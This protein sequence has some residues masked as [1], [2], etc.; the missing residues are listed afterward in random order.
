MKSL[1]YRFLRTLV[2]VCVCVC[3]FIKKINISN[4]FR[5][6]CISLTIKYLLPHKE[7]RT[8]NL[9]TFET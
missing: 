3:V 7:Q 8:K 5:F 9:Y 2:C 6:F 1:K 4:F